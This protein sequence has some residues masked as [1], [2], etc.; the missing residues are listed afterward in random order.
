MTERSNEQD[1]AKRLR[2]R[3]T[4]KKLRMTSAKTER[5]NVREKRKSSQIKTENKKSSKNSKKGEVK[6]RSRGLGTL[7]EAD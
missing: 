6:R 7:I 2:V 4:D 1:E 5:Q 3:V